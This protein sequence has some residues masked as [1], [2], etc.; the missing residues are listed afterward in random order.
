MAE[1]MRHRRANAKKKKN[2]EEDRIKRMS[3]FGLRI[4]TREDFDGDNYD[5]F[6]NIRREIKDRSQCYR[7]GPAPVEDRQSKKTRFRGE[8]PGSIDSDLD[9]SEIQQRIGEE[10][11][12]SSRSGC[13]GLIMYFSK[14]GHSDEDESIDLK[15]VDSLLRG[16][17][18]LN[19][20][21]R[22]GQTVMHEIARAWHTDVAQFALLRGADVNRADKYG[23]TPLHLAAAVNYAEMVFWLLSNNGK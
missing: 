13:L 12:D 4:E 14:L 6:K 8:A 17:A 5:D 11:L 3:M 10:F 20:P 7:V 1:K 9:E 22:Y 23:R 15:F 16:G 18:N 21:D 19:F 2:N